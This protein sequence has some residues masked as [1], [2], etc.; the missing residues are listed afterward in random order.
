MEHAY[1]KQMIE[2]EENGIFLVFGITRN[3]QIKF[4]HFSSVP[5]AED[6]SVQE[7]RQEDECLMMDEGFPLVQLELAGY[8]RPY[9]RHGNKYV[10][11]SPGC[12][13]KYE[14][15]QDT[16]NESGRMLQ[17]RQKDP[18]TGVCVQT[19]IQ[20]YD[21]VPVARFVNHVTNE[22]EEEQVLTYLSSF[23]CSGIKRDG[24]F[25][26]IPHNGWQKELNWRRYSFEELGFPVTQTKSIRRSSKTIEVYNTGNWS[27]KSICRWG[28]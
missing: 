12:Y 7:C 2:I 10:V 9:E 24:N 3:D 19:D 17:I 4:L 11:T 13:L 28:F 22:G 27:T 1:W 23:T 25:L 8:D 5:Q 18:L 26:Y 15:M 21:G 16:K 20:F 14:N 6:M